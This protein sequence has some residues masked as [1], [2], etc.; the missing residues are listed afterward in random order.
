MDSSNAANV[1]DDEESFYGVFVESDVDDSS[2][3]CHQYLNMFFVQTIFLNLYQFI[4]FDTIGFPRV[5]TNFQET[6]SAVKSNKT[7]R[8]KLF[9][10]STEAERFSVFGQELPVKLTETNI[11]NVSTGF[12]FKSLKSEDLVAFRRLIEGGELDK[13]KLAV[14]SNPRFLVSSGDTPSIIQ[15]R[16][17]K[18]NYFVVLLLKT[19]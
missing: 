9:R 16:H 2:K 11:P 4:L 17:F 14:N 5:F 18:A 1:S 7:A 3:F 8:F 12:T 13:V 6:L 10:S 15:V 19:F